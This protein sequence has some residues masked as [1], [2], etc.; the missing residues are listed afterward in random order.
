MVPQPDSASDA[1]PSPIVPASARWSASDRYLAIGSTLV[2]VIA[3]VIVARN[4]DWEQTARALGQLG[5]R[6]PFVLVPYFFALSCDTLAW[7]NTFE[8][9][10]QLPL[11]GLWQLRIA[12]EAVANSLPAGP[13]IAEGVKAILLQRRFAL[14][15]AEASANVVLAKVSLALSQ[16]LFLIAGLVSVVPTLQRSSH[17]ILGDEGLEWLAIGVAFGFLLFVSVALLA[18]VR[19][20]LFARIVA[21]FERFSRFH[22]AA[23]RLD[24][25]FGAFARVPQAQT[26]RAI[27]LFCCGWT[28]LGVENFVILWLLDSDVTL[29]QAIV[30]EALLSIV[31]IVFFFLPSGLGAQE[32]GYYLVLRAFG[33]PDPE[34]LTAAFMV[35]KRSKELIWIGMGYA[36]LSHLHVRVREARVAAA[37]T[38]P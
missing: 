6:A 31:R 29:A 22:D 13:A 20:K 38:K 25:A 16:A 35:V 21:R 30:M 26:F 34:V 28:C 33:V 15:L 32:A 8:H 18:L 10:A 14:P 9:P 27:A 1:L 12:S 5:A 37:L 24:Y 19:G 4:L 23:H 36:M 3:L 17:E 2:A 11:V 7:R